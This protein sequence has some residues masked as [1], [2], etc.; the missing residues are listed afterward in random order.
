MPFTPSKPSQPLQQI[1]YFSLYFKHT[2]VFIAFALK[3]FSLS[4]T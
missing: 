4:V 3:M 2:S 1:S